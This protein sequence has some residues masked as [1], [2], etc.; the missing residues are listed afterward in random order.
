MTK[1]KGGIQTKKYILWIDMVRISKDM[2]KERERGIE[3]QEG[4]VTR[5]TNGHSYK[6]KSTM[7]EIKTT[8]RKR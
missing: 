1:G 6:E 7:K 2:D 8:K 3:Q 4:K 5:K